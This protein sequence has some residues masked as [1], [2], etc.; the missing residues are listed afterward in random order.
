MQSKTTMRYH[1]LQEHTLKTDNIKYGKEGSKYSHI[2]GG[3]KNG[4]AL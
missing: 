4:T 2:T 1:N 3:N